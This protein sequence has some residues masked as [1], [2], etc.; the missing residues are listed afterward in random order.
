M[1][2][3]GLGPDECLDA[4]P[5]LLFVRVDGWGAHFSDEAP[6][7]HDINF[8]ARLGI[9]DM[10]GTEQQPVP[11]LNLV[12]DFGG[13]GMSA[14]VAILS[15][16]VARGAQDGTGSVIQTSLFEGRPTSRRCSAGRPPKATSASGAPT[17]STAA[18]RCIART[19][20]RTASGSPSAR[21]SPYSPGGSSRSWG[22]R[23]SPSRC[24]GERRG[25]A[26]RRGSPRWSGRGPRPTG[27]GR[28]PPWTCVMPS[29]T[30]AAAIQDDPFYEAGDHRR[31]RLPLRFGG[32]HGP[33][34]ELEQ[35]ITL[36]EVLRRCR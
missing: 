30:F 36:T 10:I 6:A 12:A 24:R 32:E 19:R 34:L 16:M 9:L 20:P 29:R 13:G 28:S 33:G 27:S 11:A 23:S 22:C 17:C 14:V 26:S 21:W 25:R 1:E 4:N 15:A 35:A 2:R 3:L 5:S 7:G 31:P 18:T 8:L